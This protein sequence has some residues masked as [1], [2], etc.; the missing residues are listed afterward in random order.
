MNESALM[1]GDFSG[2]NELLLKVIDIQ[3]FDFGKLYEEILKNSCKQ[4]FYIQTRNPKQIF[5]DILT[6]VKFI[7]AAGGLVE[8]AFQEYL[9]IKRLGKW[10]LPKGKVEKGEQMREAAVREVEEECGVKV[11]E[12]L[13]KLATTYHT[14]SLNGQLVLKKTNWYRMRVE[15]KPVLTPQSEEDIT[16]AIWVKGNEVEEI[17]ANTYPLILELIQ[18][19]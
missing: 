17:K 1:I 8:N 7:K 16:E 11:H 5:D 6:K 12:L 18:E 9:F 3:H 15:G 10:D 14:Y 19:I 2:N 13:E 4:Q